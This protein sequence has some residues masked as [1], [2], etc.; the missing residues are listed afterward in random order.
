MSKHVAYFTMTFEFLADALRLAYGMPDDAEIVDVII[1]HDLHFCP[2]VRALVV[3]VKH[4][5]LLEVLEGEQV[6]QI[7]P[8][9]H[10]TPDGPKFDWGKR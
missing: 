9:V 7:R 5:D 2:T 4:P 3:K 8:R 1:E 10:D 6:R